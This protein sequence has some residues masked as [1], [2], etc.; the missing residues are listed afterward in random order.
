MPISFN[1]IFLT[2]WNQVFLANCF[3][4]VSI[5]ND[6]TKGNFHDIYTYNPKEPFTY[7]HKTVMYS[8]ERTLVGMD[9]NLD[10]VVQEDEHFL[11]EIKSPLSVRFFLLLSLLFRIFEKSVPGCSG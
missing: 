5:F 1:L 9:E 11:D 8:N 4:L 10:E 7:M 6:Q 3:I 2:G